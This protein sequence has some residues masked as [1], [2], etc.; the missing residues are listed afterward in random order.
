MVKKTKKKPRFNNKAQNPKSKCKRQHTDN[1]E[2]GKGKYKKNYRVIQTRE[3]QGT[4]RTH[5][6]REKDKLMENAD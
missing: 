3:P 2:A 4:Q 1:K 6:D 5:E